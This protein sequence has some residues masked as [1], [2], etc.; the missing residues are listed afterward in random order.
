MAG[1]VAQ[2]VEHFPIKCGA[3]SSNSS[4]TTTTKTNKQTKALCL[5]PVVFPEGSCHDL[6]A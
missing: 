4:I 5:I 6:Q 2:A 1:E 3:L